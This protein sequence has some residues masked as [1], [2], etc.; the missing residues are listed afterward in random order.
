[1]KAQY[2]GDSY[3]IVKRF[4][5][6]QLA[7]LGPWSVHPMFTEEVSSEIY[8]SFSCLLGAPLLSNQRLMH[9]T[10]LVAYFACCASAVNVLLDPDTGVRLPGRTRSPSPKHIDSGELAKLVRARPSSLTA[11]FDQSYSRGH[12]PRQQL[13]AKLKHFHNNGIYCF[14]YAS[15][16]SFLFLG[17]SEAHVERAQALLGAIL[18]PGR[19]LSLPAN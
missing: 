3:D 8:K 4:I 10:D 1:V 6:E 14:G 5:L 7:P 13:L 19:L 2:L 12:E 15:H 18:P 9:S 11:V 16:A 17:L